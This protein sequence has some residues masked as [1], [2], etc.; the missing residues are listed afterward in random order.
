MLDQ[1]IVSDLS[2][3]AS[4]QGPAVIRFA[5]DSG[6]G[7]Q[8]LGAEFTKSSALSGHGF[9]TFPD[10]PAEIRAPAGTTFGVSAFQI[11]I[12]GD[13]VKTHGDAVDVLVAL[14]PAA[15]KTNLSSLR[16]GGLLIA[17][18]DAF[19][20][21]GLEKAGYA[22]SPL[23]D[24]SLDG[25]R[26]EAIEISRLTREAALPEG[27]TKKEAETARNFW[28]LG[29]VYWLFAQDRAPTAAWLK[30]KF[31][32]RPEIAAANTAALDAGHTYGDV[33]DMVPPARLRAVAPAS[34]RPGTYRTLT[35]IDGMV[36]GLAAASALSGLRLH[37]CSYP[38]TPASAIL[39]GLARLGGEGVATFQ[40]EDEIAAATAA[41][42]ASFAGGLG[43]TGTSG[44]GMA[45]KAE[46]LGLATAAELP[47]IVID[48]QR[49]GPSTGMPTKV[50]Q[51]DLNLALYGRHGEAPLPVFAAC[52]PGDS[53]ETV[54]EA[55]RVAVTYMTPVI[56]LSDAYT[57]NA[58]EPWRLPDVDTLA[59]IAIDRDIDPDGFHPFRRDAETLARPWAAPGMTGLAHRL[60]G[61]ERSS[62][63][64]HISYDPG[65]HQQMT[66]LRAAKL[67]RI[68]AALPPAKTAA[69]TDAGRVLV[70][71]WGSTQGALKTAVE[72]LAAEGHAV[73]HLHLRHLSPLPKGLAEIFAL[74]DV[75]VVAELNSG[76][77]RGHLQGLFPQVSFRGLNKVT[78][79]PFTV[80][81]IDAALREDL[82]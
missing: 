63:S 78:G 58:A 26:V 39:H 16:L 79:Q 11:Q 31:A 24:G 32:N 76:Q 69:G 82:S 75:V 81:E 52:G 77:L 35:G 37:Y 56:V 46:A 53:F 45:L 61:I 12:G 20:K 43:V 33:T 18:A 44:P 50:E 36:L 6:D 42:G 55:A 5:G 22:A 27:V 67:D 73:G 60:G 38:I 23:D 17:D 15:L 10:F 59:D 14:N 51:A 4:A 30:S 34:P 80:A 19:A 8:T 21:R 70:V 66:D 25:Y 7:I 48:V 1:P 9:M 41:I 28:A 65:N 62:G 72:D 74:Y 68:R 64:G 2:D 13:R 57:A 54:I 71:G 3:S 29:L 40:A 49:A 47:L